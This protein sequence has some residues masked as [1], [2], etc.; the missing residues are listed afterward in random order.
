MNKRLPSLI[1][2]FFAVLAGAGCK[3]YSASSAADQA[4]SKWRPLF[5][6]DLSNTT[7]ADKNNDR[8][9]VLESPGTWRSDIDRMLFSRESYENFVLDLEFNNA[10]G[11]NGGI[12]LYCSDVAKWVPNSVE[13]QIADDT[14]PKWSA[15]PK[16]RCGSFYGRQAATKFLVKKPGEWNHCTVTCVGRKVKVELN[17]ETVNRFDLARFTD[18][19]TNPDGS[20][21][22]GW[23]SKPPA[24]LPQK[25][26]IGLQGKHGDAPIRY[27]NIRI[28]ELSADEI[29]AGLADR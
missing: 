7:L 15:D 28:R 5:A 3:G 23:L 19:K 27:R 16:T 14:Y 11:T 12:I 29:K 4:G 1:T 17:G 18:A 13:V 26:R 6:D 8:A 20:K 21:A 2:L 25:G 22:P 10:P 9:W 24:G